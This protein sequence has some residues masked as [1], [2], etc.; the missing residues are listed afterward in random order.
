M[1]VY[2]F[3]QL[4]AVAAAL[5]LTTPALSRD[6]DIG[7]LALQPNGY[8][9]AALASGGTYQVSGRSPQSTRWTI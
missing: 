3:I 9:K 5:N 2:K 7:K 4:A 6:R 8:H 1:K